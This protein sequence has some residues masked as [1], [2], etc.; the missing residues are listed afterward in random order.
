[1]ERLSRRAVVLGGAGLVLAACGG[2]K[3][4]SSSGS[5]AASTGADAP[6][7]DAV[8]I[9][10]LQIVQFFMT[11]T[12][13]ADV[14][15]RLPFGLGST[16]GVILAGGPQQLDVRILD[17]NGT[18]EVLPP[19]VATR[20]ANQLDRPYWPVTVT[21]PLGR[22]QAA[23]SMDG[24]QIGSNAFF[25]VGGFAK[26][27]KTGDKL[28][29]VPTPTKA[30]AQGVTPICTRSP[31]CPLHEVSLDAV[32]G[33]GTPVVLMVATPAYCK[34]AVC[35]PTLDIVMNNRVDGIT[36][37]HAEVWKDNTFESPAP[38]LQAY[39]LQFEPAL[40]VVKGDG[41]IADRLDV[42]F[43]ADDLKASMAKAF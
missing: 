19:I 43:D 33:K 18:D 22:Y 36:Y 41:T 23:F 6:M 24:K 26:L 8:P 1:M 14:P 21:L 16:S 39:G 3:G 20:H 30:D 10:E 40:F 35:G 11:G 29:V 9:D 34:T 28:P 42:I 13:P 4:G 12:P 15:H 7:A 25:D 37:I 17:A 38:L 31:E 27:P 2:S 32:L 5:T